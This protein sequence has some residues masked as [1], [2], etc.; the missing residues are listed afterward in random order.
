MIIPEA[1]HPMHPM[2]SSMLIELDKSVDDTNGLIYVPI[3]KNYSNWIKYHLQQASYKLYNYYDQGFDSDKHMALI[4]LRDPIDRWISAMGQ[5]LV[6]CSPG[7]H[8]HVDQIDWNEMTKTIYRNNHTQPQHEFFANI[9]HD[10]IVWFR[11]DDQFEN[12]F[13]KL[14]SRYGIEICVMPV[15]NDVDNVFNVTSKIP[16]RSIGFYNAPPQQVIVDKI[17]KVL[18]ENPEYVKRLQ[19][20]YQQDYQLLNTVPY[21]DPR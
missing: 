16:E 11:C 1:Y 19:Q 3:P 14:L 5:I 10:R 9:P 13:T 12:N 2:G 21:Y 7:W 20:L 8:M 17:K 18:D 15:D 6:G 4:V